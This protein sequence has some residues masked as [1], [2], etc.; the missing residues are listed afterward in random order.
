MWDFVNGNCDALYLSIRLYIMK[1]ELTNFPD[2][3]PS[4]CVFVFIYLLS[5]I[6]FRNFILWILLMLN[7]IYFNILNQTL[8]LCALN[9]V[10]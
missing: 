2:R 9:Q 4:G 1:Q 10:L 3:I 8:L 6:S 7:V 5:F